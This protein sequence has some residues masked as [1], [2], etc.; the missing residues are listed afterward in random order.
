MNNTNP[1]YSLQGCTNEKYLLCR[2]EQSLT[3]IR[4]ISK[5]FQFIFD[6]FSRGMYS[7]C[8]TNLK[9]Y[10]TQH[11]IYLYLPLAES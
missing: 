8:E 2:A 11:N 4:R 6:S 9:I 5:T 10:N 3:E 7:I 1:I